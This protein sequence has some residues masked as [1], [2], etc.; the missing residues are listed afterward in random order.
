MINYY[1]CPKCKSLLYSRYSKYKRVCIF[2]KVR[3]EC[4]NC[5]KCGYFEHKW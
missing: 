1:L 4:F 2:K 3:I 5:P